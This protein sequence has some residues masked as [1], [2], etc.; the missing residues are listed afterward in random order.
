M[1][2]GS[3]EGLEM[4]QNDKQKIE[5]GDGKSYTKGL[6]SCSHGADSNS[7][8]IDVKN[9][10]IVRIRPLQFDWKYD[11]EGFN[12]W[13]MEAHGKVFE[14]RMKSLIPPYSLAYKKRVYSPNRVCYPLKRVDWDPDG[15]RNPEKRGESKYVRISWDEAI[16]TI[17]KEIRRIKE[18]VIGCQAITTDIDTGIQRAPGVRIGQPAPRIF[19]GHYAPVIG[20]V[21]CKCCASD[22]QDSAGRIDLEAG[23]HR[24]VADGDSR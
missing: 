4:V 20:D 19:C 21:V 1:T 16:N 10:K 11:K 15:E 12:P 8:V 5:A 18:I 22:I 23:P 9:G 6:G 24:G 13:K 14:P 2:S 7:S 17:V 3:A